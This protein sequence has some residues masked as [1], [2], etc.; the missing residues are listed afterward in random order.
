MQIAVTNY[1]GTLLH[2]AVKKESFAAAQYLLQN[3][4]HVMTKDIFNKLPADYAKSPE[5]RK[6]LEEYTKPLS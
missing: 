1:D 2:L 3:G 6:L 4:A 5:M